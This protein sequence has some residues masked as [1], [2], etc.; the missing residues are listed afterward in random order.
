M[1]V[2]N[3]TQHSVGIVVNKQ[4]KGKVLADRINEYTK[5]SKSRGNLLKW[6]KEK[7][8]KREEATEQGTWIQLKRQLK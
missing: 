3:I 6:V 2:Y 4:V 8:Q 7:D 5:H 1:E